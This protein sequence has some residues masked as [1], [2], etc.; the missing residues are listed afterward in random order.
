VTSAHSGAS[1]KRCPT[2]NAAE[3]TMIKFAGK[4]AH[5]SDAIRTIAILFRELIYPSL[6]LITA[7]EIS[8]SKNFQ[9]YVRYVSFL[10]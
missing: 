2:M 5:K 3:I 6:L 9:T 10:I 7:T 1:A 8:E 4:I